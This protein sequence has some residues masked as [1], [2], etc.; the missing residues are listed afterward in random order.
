MPE[1]CNYR[2]QSYVFFHTDLWL[3]YFALCSCIFILFLFLALHTK[4]PICIANTVNIFSMA[5][6]VFCN[7]FLKTCLLFRQ[8][9]ITCFK[10][11]RVSFSPYSYSEKVGWNIICHVTWGD[12]V[13][14]GLPD[15]MFGVHWSRING[16]VKYLTWPREQRV[17][18]LY[19]KTPQGK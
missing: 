9:L 14:K 4:S 15:L 5:A 13:F 10:C 7:L 3:E 16:D 18:R 11:S 8:I 1:G 17:E 6:H 12:H 19:G 2:S